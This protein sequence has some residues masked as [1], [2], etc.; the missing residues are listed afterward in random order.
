MDKEPLVYIVLPVYNWQKYFLE[1]LMS[2]YYQN[3]KNWFLVIVNDWSTDHSEEIAKEFV[4]N[5]E[6]E[7]KVKI[8]NKENWWLNSA[9]TRWFEEIKKICDIHTFDDFVCYCDCDDIRTRK[10]L[11]LQV[12][13][14]IKNPNC[15]LSYHDLAIIDENWIIKNCSKMKKYKYKEDKNFQIIST[16]DPHIT[17]TSMMFKVSCIEDILPMPLWKDMCQDWWTALILSFLWWKIRYINVP[18]W[19]YRTWNMSKFMLLKNKKNALSNRET[20]LL[21]F[22]QSRFPDVDLS[23]V[24]S[25]KESICW[26]NFKNKFEKNIYTLFNYPKIFFI[27]LKLFLIEMIKYKLFKL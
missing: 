12:E 11:S 25:Y 15:G 16:M 8:I 21:K 3:Y 2:I 10:K 5:Y 7:H 22:L 26:K 6:L 17:A 4:S 18:L 24:I 20:K 14:M 13:Y 27:Q 23:N 19:Y 9:I 1:Q